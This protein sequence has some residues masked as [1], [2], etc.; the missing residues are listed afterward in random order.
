MQELILWMMVLAWPMLAA[1]DSPVGKCDPVEGPRLEWS[2]DDRAEVRGQLRTG[3]RFVGGSHAYRVFTASV[4]QRESF[5]GR[6]SVRHSLGEGERGLGPLGLNIPSHRDKW[7]G[8]D[9]DPQFCRPAVSF[10]VFHAVVWRA[11]HVYHASDWVDVQAVYSGRFTITADGSFP[12]PNERTERIICGRM[13]ARGVSC[14]EPI[15][16]RDIGR[17]VRFGDRRAAAD[18]IE[19]LHKEQF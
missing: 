3:V 10:L 6:A 4:A 11:V 15:G 16:A 2:D 9:E 14:Y 7:P 12:D 18:K 5:N 13:E 17:K 19:S 8:D 1:P